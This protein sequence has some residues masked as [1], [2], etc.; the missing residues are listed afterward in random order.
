MNWED[1]S[2]G[3]KGWASRID[4]R[5]LGQTWTTSSTFSRKCRTSRISG[6]IWSSRIRCKE[7]GSQV[8]R[9]RIWIEV[10]LLSPSLSQLPPTLSSQRWRMSHRSPWLLSKT[11]KYQSIIR[12]VARRKN[13]KLRA[14]L[15]ITFYPSSTSARR[16]VILSQQSSISPKPSS[17][18]IVISRTKRPVDWSKV[19]QLSIVI[20][21]ARPLS[22]AI[23]KRAKLICFQTLPVKPTYTITAMRNLHLWSTLPTSPAIVSESRERWHPMGQS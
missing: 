15:L 17:W 4:C 11:K 19:I 16:K 21:L 8:P 18:P 7:W 13:L 23:N 9:I 14:S 5:V 1:H 12:S 10:Q 3:F 6:E 22:R 2:R 20:K